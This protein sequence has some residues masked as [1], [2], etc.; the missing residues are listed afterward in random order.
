[1]KKYWIIYKTTI[2]DS[3]NRRAEML[4]YVLEDFISPLLSILLWIGVINYAGTIQSGWDVN[5]TVSYFL[6]TAFL[7]LALNHYVDTLVGYQHIAQ[8]GLAEV[9]LKPMSYHGYVFA[10]ETGW[11]TVRL[12]MSMIPFS[13]FVWMFRHYLNFTMSPKQIALALLFSLLAYFIIFL[14]K[15]LVGMSAFWVTENDGIVHASW[16]IQAIFAGRLIPYA[17]LPSTLQKISQWLPHQ[18]FFYIPANILLTEPLPG[19]IAKNIVLALIWICIL[20]VANKWMF[21]NGLKQFTD[22]K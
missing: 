5:R 16:A 11:K 7:V 22:T 10:T 6:V 14:F 1:M 8:G 15:F 17:F 12:L 13:F 18:F 9:L 4:V 21:H 3:V 2:L 19:E 20:S